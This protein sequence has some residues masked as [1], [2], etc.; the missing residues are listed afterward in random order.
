MVENPLNENSVM[1]LVKIWNKTIKGKLY[2]VGD[3]HGCYDL[4][5][6]RL[7]EIGF[8]FENDLLVAVGDLVDRGIQN[9]ECVN[10]IDQP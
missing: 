1:N 10:L 8:N 3:I 9:I 4:L 7:I 5:M 2:V 6:S